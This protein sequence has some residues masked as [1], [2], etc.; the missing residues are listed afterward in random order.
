VVFGHE[1]GHRVHPI[2][3]EA[4]YVDR[5]S[6]L[7]TFFRYF[8]TLPHAIVSTVWGI[9]VYF[10]AFFA[11][12]AIL[13]TGSYPL[14]MYDFCAKWLRYNGRVGAY[15][16]LLGDAFPPFNGDDPYTARVSTTPQ[17]PLSRLTTFFRGIW[18]IPA[19]VIIVFYALA[20]GVVVLAAWVVILITGSMP[21]SLHDFIQGFHRYAVRFSAYALLLTD[22]YPSP[23]P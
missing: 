2:Q 9:P 18:I 23:S 21:H 17:G 5:R 14:G 11:W 10:V 4:D 22:R 8:T 3:F 6:R 16:A 15:A 7:T 13:F 19:Y 1:G 20:A 12:F